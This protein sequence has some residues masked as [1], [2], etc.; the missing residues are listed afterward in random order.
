MTLSAFSSTGRFWRGNLHAH[1]TRS[2]GTLSPENVCKKYR[3]A[4][5]DF[6]AVT[7]H[8][9][10]QYDYPLVDTSPY[11]LDDFT[12]LI[13]AELHGGSTQFGSMWHI[14][15]VG[16]PDRLRECAVGRRPRVGAPSHGSRRLRC[17]CAPAVVHTDRI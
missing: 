17:H 1:S 15:A 4:G 10:E 7:D 13:G 14:L 6:V 3:E 8:F 5:Y 12:T 2:D 16:L 9:L 11:R